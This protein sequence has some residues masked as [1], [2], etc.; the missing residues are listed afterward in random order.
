MGNR[1]VI[2]GM[3]VVCSVGNTKDEFWESIAVGKSGIDRV[4]HFDPQDFRTQIGGE[5]KGFAPETYLPRKAV[6]RLPLFIQYA[7]VSAI[8]AQQNADL[9][10]SSIDPYR[11]GVG[12]GS[13]IGGIGI[14]EDNHRILMEKGPRRVSPFFVPYEIINMAAGQISIHLKLKGPQFRICYRLCNREQRYRGIVQNYPT[15][16]C[17]CDVY[18]RFRGRNY[19]IE[20]CRVLR[21]ACHV[22]AQRRTA[23]GKPTI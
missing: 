17:R 21:H 10:L 6:A 14:L 20:F 23:A 4:T 9:D 5:I 16:R 15:W 12:V 1:V 2:T 11:V 8:Q 18:R 22:H 19:P 7:L 3:G 13:G